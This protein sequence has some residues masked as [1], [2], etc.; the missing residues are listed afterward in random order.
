MSRAQ[1]MYEQGVSDDVKRTMNNATTSARGAAGWMGARAS[2]GW[3]SVNEVAR[4]RGGVDL[5][6]KFSSLGLSGPS[7]RDQGYG[8]V[9][10]SPSGDA[11]FDAWEPETPTADTPT[12]SKPLM[13]TQA[14]KP[15]QA[16]KK[17]NWD[18]DDW[19]DF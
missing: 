8:Q 10:Q 17:D 9:G 18:D 16:K 3:D 11:F 1:E 19:K 12:S 2:E 5:N 7:A 15:V 6:A 14:P 13:G 4:T